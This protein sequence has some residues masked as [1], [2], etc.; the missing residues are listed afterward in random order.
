MK[1]VIQNQEKFC[2]A[3]RRFN[4]SYSREKVEDKIIDFAISVE[5]LFS[6]KND[7]ID[8]IAYKLA[9]RISRLWKINDLDYKKIFK[10]IKNFYDAR[11]KIVHGDSKEREK[12]LKKVD[13]DNIDNIIRESLRM[14]I[15]RLSKDEVSHD[16]LM[17][18]LDFA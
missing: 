3:L 10:D 13:V 4:Y 9:T 16:G 18:L 8:S 14:Y 7:G 2:L 15:E 6:K 11:S 17:E 5:A 12:S 1:S